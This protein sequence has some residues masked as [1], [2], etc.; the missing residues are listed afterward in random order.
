MQFQLPFKGTEADGI[1]R[2]NQLLA[3]HKG[4]IEKKATNVV[5]EW[6]G[7]VLSFSFTAQ[8]NHIEGTLTVKEGEFDVHAKLPLMLRMFEGTIERMIQAEVAKLAL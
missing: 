1:A 6:K 4:E 8:G 5:T 2:V 3:E 7:N